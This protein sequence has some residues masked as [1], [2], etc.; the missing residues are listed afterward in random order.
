MDWTLFFSAL[1]SATLF[2]GGSEALL[3]YRLHEGG[4]ALSLVLIA[5]AGNV[6]GSLIT[7]AMGRAGN[8]AV[9]RHWLRIS[10][11]ATAR[12]E[13][14]FHRFGEPA[15]LFAW[16]P[17]VGDP[18][19]LVAGLLRCHVGMFLILVTMGKLARYTLLAWAFF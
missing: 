8:E 15:L 14:W 5:T 17:V 6:L 9:H 13:R 7:Y 3:L 10:E 12:A 1:I 19:C 18:L 4:H 2:P 16:L 11:D